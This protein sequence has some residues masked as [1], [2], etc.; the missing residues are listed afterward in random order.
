M[1]KPL[2]IGIIGAGMIG[3]AIG[4]TLAAMDHLDVRLFTIEKD[5]TE[6]INSS[7]LNQKYYPNI[8]LSPALRAHSDI[9]A[10]K[11]SDILFLAIPSVVAVDF[12][13]QNGQNFNE[14]TIII[15]LAKGFGER[16]K[17][18]TECLEAFQPGSIC[19]LK[20]PTFAREIINGVPTAFTFAAA[21]QKLFATMSQL[22]NGTNIYLDYTTDVKGTEVVS[23]LKNIYAIVIGIID[24]HFDSPNLRFLFLTRAFNEMKEI[25]LELGGR[26]QTM[27]RYCG[28]GD[29][30]LTALNDLSR[31]RTLGL[32]IGK[33]FF[34][35]N[36]SDKVVLEGKIAVNEIIRHLDGAGKANKRYPVIYE[37]YRVFNEE[38]NLSLFVNR[39]LNNSDKQNI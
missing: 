28:F 7:G 13:K 6:S 29:F 21:D 18:I 25:M 1:T 14:D 30:S 5:V 32:L 33:G 9:E 23:I 2:Q 20:G 35:E 16:Q 15:N 38:Y 12:L 27:F 37:L 36:I 19:S 17:T 8:K 34:I 26:E 11:G 24:A 3:T 4:N 31:N 39:L 22:F 10:L